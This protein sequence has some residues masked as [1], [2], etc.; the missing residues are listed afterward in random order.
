M[1]SIF[2][3]VT[4]ICW[5]MSAG[6]PRPL[7]RTSRRGV[8]A[9]SASAAGRSSNCSSAGR[10]SISSGCG[11]GPSGPVPCHGAT[12]QTCASGWTPFRRSRG[13]WREPSRLPI[14]D[15][16]LQIHGLPDC[17][18]KTDGLA[19]PDCRESRAV[20]AGARAFSQSSIANP[21][22]C[23]RRS[24]IRESAI[25]SRQSAIACLR[26]A[27]AP[28]PRGARRGPARPG[29]RRGPASRAAPAIPRA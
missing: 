13:N 23:N 5:H 12:R 29:D 20:M 28:A 11:S 27:A 6:K 1:P 3:A 9:G 19:M 4:G 16:R 24:P 26:R 15:C 17:R 21:S 8:P 18:L 7:R 14:A 25:C 10:P 22:V 2:H